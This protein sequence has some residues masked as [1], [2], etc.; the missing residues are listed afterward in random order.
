MRYRGC[1]YEKTLLLESKDSVDRCGEIVDAFVT[2]PA[3]CAGNLGNDVRVVF[4]VD[5]PPHGSR[6]IGILYDNP[7][8]AKPVVPAALDVSG[9]GCG[10]AVDARDYA[11]AC[12]PRSGVIDRSIFR[13]RFP[14]TGDVASAEAAAVIGLP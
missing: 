5:V 14:R 9:E 11:V 12:D 10:L 1:N 13:Q 3:E 7:A 6:R 2:V 4:A 8:A